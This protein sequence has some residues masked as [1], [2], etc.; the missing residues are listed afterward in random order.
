METIAP[1]GEF[2]IFHFAAIAELQVKK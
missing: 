2:K 1:E